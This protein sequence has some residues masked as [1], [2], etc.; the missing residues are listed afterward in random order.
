[1]PNIKIKIDGRGAKK[2]EIKFLM[3]NFEKFKSMMEGTT[4]SVVQESAKTIIQESLKYV[5][6][7]TGALKESNRFKIRA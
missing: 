1:V 4:R 5:P 7:Q 3:K 6:E 2:G